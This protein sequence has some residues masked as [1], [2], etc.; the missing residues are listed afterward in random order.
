MLKKQKQQQQ[1]KATT[2]TIGSDKLY[3]IPSF[4]PLTSSCHTN[5]RLLIKLFLQYVSGYRKRDLM[6]QTKKIEFFMLI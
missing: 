4:F 2:K 6:A 1:K 3:I 5:K